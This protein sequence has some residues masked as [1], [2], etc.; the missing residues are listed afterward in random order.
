MWFRLG[1][2]FSLLCIFWSYTNIFNVYFS[3]ESLNLKEKICHWTEFS[4]IVK[5]K[6]YLEYKNK[7]KLSRLSHCSLGW[8][9]T[10]YQ[11]IC[12]IE[13]INEK[14]S[15]DL[16]PFYLIYMFSSINVFHMLL[17]YSNVGVWFSVLKTLMARR[18]FSLPCL[19]SYL[20]LQ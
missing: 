1:H 20:R 8:T 16:R 4:S 15:S 17:C 10:K 7:I 18:K 6:S 19:F 12:T 2:A 14:I 3:F 11:Q 13:N 5:K 9:T